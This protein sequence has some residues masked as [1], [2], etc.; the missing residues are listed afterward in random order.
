MDDNRSDAQVREHYE[1]ERQLAAR[2]LAASKEERRTLY[3]AL[4]EELFRRVPHHTQLTRKAS[5]EDR[6]RSV[7]YQMRLLSRFLRPDASFL[8]LGPGDCAL[9]FAVADVVKKVYAVDV[10]PTIS[11]S[12]A[13]PKNFKLVISDGCTI[14]VPDGEIDVAFSNQLMEHLHPDDAVE[15]LSNVYRALAPGGIYLCITPN[16]LSG[17]HDISGRFDTVATGFHL[18]EYTVTEL[19]SLFKR[20]GF[21]KTMIFFKVLGRYRRV[22]VSLVT[23]LEAILQALPQN[24]RR[25]A[26]RHGTIKRLINVRLVGVKP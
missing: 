16:R 10:S 8:E 15:Q 7:D 21:V 1:I 18:K 19:D 4:Y 2:L 13:V 22:P 12:D 11:Y 9:A 17:P 24:F 14:P 26:S 20:V 5:L 23:T 3:G 25:A 6:K